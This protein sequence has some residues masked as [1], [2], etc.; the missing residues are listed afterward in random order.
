M[1]I[2]YDT[3]FLHTDSVKRERHGMVWEEDELGRLSRLFLR[4]CP[5]EAICEKLK[6]PPAGV[7]SKLKQA[8]L[9]VEVNGP[10][11]GWRPVYNVSAR[12]CRLAAE[13][14]YRLP[15]REP[16]FRTD[17]Q[18]QPQPQKETAMKTITITTITN[19][20]LVN[21]RNV[22]DMPDSELFSLIADEEARIEELSKIKAQPKRLK[23]EIAK[24]QQAV[25]DLVALLDKE[26]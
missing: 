6:R 5:L 17:S 12:A 9:L 14:P 15:G 22:K 24:R 25:L 10:D 19:Q 3:R 2:E 16:A 26:A 18:S 20:T 8:G 23:D 1:R 4:G 7:L 11:Q 21:G 13:A